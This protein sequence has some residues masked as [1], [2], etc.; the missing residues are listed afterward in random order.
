MRDV[1]VLG[2]LMVNAVRKECVG[3]GQSAEK[4]HSGADCVSQ[5][6]AAVAV[7]DATSVY[8]RGK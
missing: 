3:A 8:I 6:G 2:F 1:V 4:C 5:K 7:S